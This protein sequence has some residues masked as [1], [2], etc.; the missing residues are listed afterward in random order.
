MRTT[1]YV[2]VHFAVAGCEAHCLP[3]SPIGT[4][5]GDATGRAPANTPS[6]AAVLDTVSCGE[7]LPPRIANWYRGRCYPWLTG[8]AALEAESTEI[9]SL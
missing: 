6:A 4:G 3:G 9:D 1:L 7:R 5:G 2:E 8:T